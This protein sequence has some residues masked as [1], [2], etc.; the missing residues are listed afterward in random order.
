MRCKKVYKE[1][2]TILFYKM[3][4]INIS[5]KLFY[6]LVVLGVCFLLSVGVY[7]YD[8][9]VGASIMGHSADELDIAQID[10]SNGLEWGERG[11]LKPNQGASIELGGEGTPYIDFSN[12]AT[13]DFDARMILDNDDQLRVA[14]GNLKV[15][16]SIIVGGDIPGY[17]RDG[18]AGN[19]L[20]STTLINTNTGKNQDCNS[21]LTVRIDESIYKDPSE[22]QYHATCSIGGCTY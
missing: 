16:G 11:W 5:N 7:A 6:S 17:L 15:D 4:T 22:C 14:G 10:F 3:V 21:K 9:N 8:S 20:E 13:S 1:L 19:A 2:F 12:D 18:E